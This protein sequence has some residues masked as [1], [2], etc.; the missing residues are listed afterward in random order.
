MTPKHLPIDSE[1]AFQIALAARVIDLDV[2]QFVAVLIKALGTPLSQHRL[3]KLRIN[4]LKQCLGRLPHLQLRIQNEWSSDQL[5]RCVDLLKGRHLP[6]ISE[7]SW[8]IQ[9]YVHGQM[10]NSIRIACACIGQEHLDAGFNNCKQ[11]LIYQ[12]ATNEA[13]LVAVRSALQRPFAPVANSEPPSKED[14]LNH[15]IGQLAD[16]VLF[17]TLSIGGLAAA[18]LIRSNVL[19]LK[20][21]P[22]SI[23]QLLLTLQ[24][25]LLLPPPWLAK[26]MHTQFEQPQ[27][28][29]QEQSWS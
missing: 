12:V 13:R 19:V 27:L 1:V 20:T 10:P 7:P 9:P 21:Q 23:S 25:A 22:Q 17:Y 15:N 4:R 6:N 11:F 14:C 3:N 26:A 8:A 28:S 5:S 29:F 2:A 24:E 16:C 18:K